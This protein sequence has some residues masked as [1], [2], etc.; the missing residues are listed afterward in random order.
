M[1][2]FDRE[3]ARDALSLPA[4]HTVEVFIAIGRRGDPSG[5]PD[6]ARAREQPNDRRPLAELVH[7]GSFGG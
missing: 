1:G 7:E 6:W 2:G 4:D 5:L 3:K